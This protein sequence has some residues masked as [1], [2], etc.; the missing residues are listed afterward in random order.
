MNRKRCGVCECVCVVMVIWRPLNSWL[1]WW[2]D[3]S[4]WVSGPNFTSRKVGIVQLPKKILRPMNMTERKTGNWGKKEVRS[5][6]QWVKA[7]DGAILFIWVKWAQM[8]LLSAN[9][10]WCRLIPQTSGTSH[11]GWHR[12]Q[13]FPSTSSEV[14]GSTALPSP[15]LRWSLVGKSFSASCKYRHFLFDCLLAQIAPPTLYLWH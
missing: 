3:V 11:T 10:P 7:R 1:W 14:L 13:H 8:G 2:Q 5:E 9:R 12:R 4:W 6:R 15:C